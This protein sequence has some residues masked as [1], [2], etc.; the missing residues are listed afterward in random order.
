MK[1]IYKS[2]FEQALAIFLTLEIDNFLEHFIN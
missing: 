1:N 2:H